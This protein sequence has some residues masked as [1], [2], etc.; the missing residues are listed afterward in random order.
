MNDK[1]LKVI[2]KRMSPIEQEAVGKDSPNA[3]I[4]KAMDKGY[5]PEL[6]EKMMNLQERYDKSIAK[7][8]YVS[9]MAD[10]KKNPPKIEKDRHVQ[11]NTSKGT[12]DYRH[13][14][15]AN[16][17]EKISSALGE[18]GLSASWITDQQNEN[19][20]VTCTITH[21]LGHSESTSLS[22]AA[23]LSGSKNAIQAVGSTISYLQRYTLLA[24][25]GLAT[26]DMDDDGQSLEQKELITEDQVTEL[27]DL[28]EETKTLPKAFLRSYNRKSLSDF[29]QDD[30]ESAKKF[31]SNKKR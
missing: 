13:A 15:L 28:I 12:V 16:V 18:N 25:T 1:Q 26:H 4:I 29:T 24:L 11:Y 6:I 30:Y 9:A 2:D 10:F 27:N 5:A 21:E 23:D 17:T 14:S 8:A 20:K 3:M 19:I 22:G 31:F 7:K